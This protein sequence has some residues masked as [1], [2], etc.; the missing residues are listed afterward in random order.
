MEQNESGCLWRMD[1]RF[2]RFLQIDEKWN[3][4]QGRLQ[5]FNKHI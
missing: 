3:D 5:G 2:Y 1:Q 4:S